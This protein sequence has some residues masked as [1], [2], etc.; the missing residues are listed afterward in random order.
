[1]P[2]YRRNY[3][4]G[5]TYNR[6]YGMYNRYTTKP[7]V[8]LRPGRGMR[9]VR[10]YRG[11]SRTGVK[12]IVQS[13]AEHKYVDGG[14][15]VPLQVGYTGYINAIS[16]AELGNTDTTRVG[17]K[18]TGVSIQLKMRFWLPDPDTKYQDGGTCVRILVFIWKDDATPTSSDIFEET[19]TINNAALLMLNHDKK[20]RRRILL[21]EVHRLNYN[22]IVPLEGD[23]IP[24][25]GP[26]SNLFL[27]RYINLSNLPNRLKIVNYRTGDTNMN[28][29][30]KIYL[31]VL[32]DGNPPGEGVA[33]GPL[34][35]YSSRYNF[36]DM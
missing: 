22:I 29:V 19:P 14:L 16:N 23:P 1:M 10:P 36:I 34:F 24:A 28:G 21:D 11:I 2:G 4:R 25:P 26:N 7:F 20:I 27:K 18:T 9:S 31:L 35:D 33:E 30:N 15:N 17:D 6:M 5:R 12:K 8:K 13:M 3:S 32:T